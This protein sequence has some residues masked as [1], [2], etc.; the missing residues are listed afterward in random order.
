MT[1]SGPLFL[2]SEQSREVAGTPPTIERVTP[3]GFKRYTGGY[4]WHTRPGGPGSYI[5]APCPAMLAVIW[6]AVMFWRLDLSPWGGPV[7]GK[8][9][10]DGSPWGFSDVAQVPGVIGYVRNPATAVWADS[11]GASYYAYTGGGRDVV[12]LDL[13]VWRIWRSGLWITSITLPFDSAR[14][15]STAATSNQT[16]QA[17]SSSPF[18]SNFQTSRPAVD[19]D[20][21]TRATKTASVSSDDPPPIQQLFT[22]EVT[23][24]GIIT[25]P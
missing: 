20:T 12:N 16:V 9:R 25:M 17:A 11:S 18:F 21:Q 14:I 13:D 6:P 7:I 1:R 3:W 5:M 19:W 24:A 22:V 4:N 23:D 8:C 10:S 2:W 15:T